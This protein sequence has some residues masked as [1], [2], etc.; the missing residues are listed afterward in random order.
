MPSRPPQ[1][2]HAGWQPY[3]VSGFT[4]TTTGSSASRGY[5]ADWRHL[6]NRILT[7]EPLCRFCAEVGR[8]EPAT[9]VDHIQSFKGLTDPLRLDPRNCRP[10]CVPCH[11]RRTQAQ[12]LGSRL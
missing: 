12:S 9:E 1:H 10:L 6:R 5:G 2:R 11:R 3:A 8:V 4:R 7:A